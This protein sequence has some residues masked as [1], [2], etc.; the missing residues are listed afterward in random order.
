M[1][2]H[3][4]AWRRPPADW[5]APWPSLPAWHVGLWEAKS[6][7]LMEFEN[8]DDDSWVGQCPA[9]RWDPSHMQLGRF[10][11]SHVTKAGPLSHNE[12]TIKD[13]AVIWRICF[14]ARV[15]FSDV[16]KP[17]LARTESAAQLERSL[18]SEFAQI[19][20]IHRPSCTCA[21]VLQDFGRR[22]SS[23]AHVWNPDATLWLL[24]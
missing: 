8:W 10:R 13:V 12:E 5:L 18:S 11:G 21:W 15:C 16:D 24:L 7:I 20:A 9:G 19:K 4:L 17:K 1:S 14:V 3:Q 2:S 23:V 6:C 22:P